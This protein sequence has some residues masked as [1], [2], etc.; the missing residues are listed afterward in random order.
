MRAVHLDRC[1]FLIPRYSLV[2]EPDG[3]EPTE[4]LDAKI[5]RM[6]A[7]GNDSSMSPA[8]GQGVL[9]EHVLY[10]E[11]YA[12]AVVRSVDRNGYVELCFYDGV[13]SCLLAR[14]D[15]MVLLDAAAHA[16]IVEAITVLENNWV[17]RQVICRDDGDGL[18]YP[19]RVVSRVGPGARYRVAL[20]DPDADGLGR[21]VAESHQVKSHIF[22]SDYDLGDDVIL[23]VGDGVVV[24]NGGPGIIVQAAGRQGSGD[25]FVV[26][27]WDGRQLQV[28]AAMCYH[29]GVEYVASASAYIR[30]L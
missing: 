12:P 7:V 11:S 6:P 15:P 20:G 22:S 2:T 18:F 19:G 28:P 21:M 25:G 9:A 13:S 30:S 29:C 24:E 3:S 16:R 8:V 5:F 23:E 27:A 10:R 1:R 14:T 17:G 4:V 26:E